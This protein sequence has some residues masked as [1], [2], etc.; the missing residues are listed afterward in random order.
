MTARRAAAALLVA[1][2]ITLSACGARQQEPSMP[3]PVESSEE[4]HDDAAAADT[5]I[6]SAVVAAVRFVCSGQRLLDTS[7]T[8]LGDAVRSM[9]SAE[10]ADGALDATLDRL[11]ELRDRLG[12]GVGPTRFRQAALAVR[13]DSASA[14]RVVVSVWWVGVLSRADAVTPQAQW[15]ISTVTMVSES[16]EWKVDAESTEPGPLPD[17]SVDSEPITHAEMERRLTGFVDWS[18]R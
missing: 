17:H 10:S 1:L 15:S 6:D 2:S 9:W 7:P 14:A 18:G 4:Q 11:S 5:D 16:G 8:A 12:G 3:T 13:V